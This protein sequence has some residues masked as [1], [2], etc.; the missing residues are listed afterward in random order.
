MNQLNLLW[1]LQEI[2]QQLAKKAKALGELERPK[3]IEGKIQTHKKIK[4]DYEDIKSELENSKQNLRKTEQELSELHFKKEEMKGKLYGGKI[5]DLKVLGTMMKEQDKMDIEYSQ[6][7]SN[8]VE[9]MELVESTEKK[10]NEVYKSERQMG[11]KIKHML[12]ERKVEIEKI[13]NEI[14]VLSSRQEELSKKID[15]QYMHIYMDVKKRKV[16]P[17][18]LVEED[19]C[20]G[21]HMDLPIMTLSDLKNKKLVTCNNCNR[22]LY[23][24]TEI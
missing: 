17:M 7:E 19:T 24:P 13:K 12:N 3:E 22:I 1:Q 15:K 11:S 4:Q 8:L 18:A 10:A 9:Q 5:N 21:C 23:M 16:N 20:T 6:V 2:E 14:E